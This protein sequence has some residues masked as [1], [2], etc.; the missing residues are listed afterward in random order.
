MRPSPLALKTSELVGGGSPVSS[1]WPRGRS[2]RSASTPARRS[3]FEGTATPRRDKSSS[4]HRP[5]PRPSSVNKRG[6][7]FFS[8]TSTYLPLLRCGRRPSGCTWSGTPEPGVQPARRVSIPELARRAR[9]K[10]V[11]TPKAVPVGIWVRTHFHRST[12]SPPRF[13]H[14]E[15][16][17]VARR[18]DGVVF[19]M[20]SHGVGGAGGVRV[21]TTRGCRC[22]KPARRTQEISLHSF[23][24]RRGRRLRC[25]VLGHTFGA[26][27]LRLIVCGRPGRHR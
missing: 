10:A 22:R 24:A 12:P 3:I 4:W 18:K 14:R 21:W 26:G 20:T 25:H 2:W 8:R 17:Q 15:G 19:R 7:S 11:N 6:S 5:S 16:G 13:L 27:G 9:R 1:G 23:P